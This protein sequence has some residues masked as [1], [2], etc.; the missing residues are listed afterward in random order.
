MID[1]K[2]L[3]KALQ[4]Q[5]ILLE[6]D[7]TPTGLADA[8]LKVE[9]RAAKNAD[10]TAA[11][12]ETW[13]GE[14]VTQVAVA[15]VLGTV[16][17]RF[18]EDNGLIE[19]PF[20]TGPGERADLA[21]DLQ[22]EYF[23]K[24]PEQTDRDWIIAG[25]DAMSVSPVAKGLFDRRHNPMWTISPSHDAA[26][27]L[28]AFWRET[29]PDGQVV[30]DLTDPEWNTRFL[31]DLYQDLSEAARKTYALLQTPEFVEEFILKYT[32]D[33]AIE[34]FGLTPA[35][36]P[37]HEDLPHR[38]RVI[39]PACGSGHFL[40]G[41]FRKLL[42][43]W[44]AEKPGADK[45][46]LIREALAS[47]HG[48]DKNPFAVAIARFRLMLAA[49]R[50]GGV[51]R[52]SDQVDFPLNIAVGDSL[53]HGKGAPGRQVEFD[54]GGETS[55]HS[56]RTEDVE[57]FIKSV[58]ILEVGTYHVVVGNPPYITA[59]DKAENETL[60]QGLRELLG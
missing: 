46:E 11:T 15:W 52:L 9:W 26:K 53:L 1:S 29:G 32:L 42:A 23:Q 49:M 36:P 20:I 48:V 43:A 14:R 56:Y 22:A 40:L 4:K 30:Y 47:V 5:V 37:G 55:T 57:D 54:F 60:P 59:K 27:A 13:L 7:L 8:R 19:Y 39:D 17:L 33:P 35:P 50:A 41:A 21:R 24:H 16:F 38:L 45:W 44:E 28:L 12:F 10:R 18:C 25:F 3:L 58:H 6:K 51:K 2:V 31:G 34:E